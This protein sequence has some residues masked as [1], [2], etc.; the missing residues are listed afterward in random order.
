MKGLHER[1]TRC[2]SP[3]QDDIHEQT[4]GVE[5]ICKAYLQIRDRWRP[6]HA[7]L[8]GV[9]V[10]HEVGRGRSPTS[11]E[12]AL[13]HQCRNRSAKLESKEHYGEGRK[14]VYDGSKHV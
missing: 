12:V 3:T 7:W 14:A 1:L 4:K 6:N 11:L 10:D 9:R 13:F 5:R 8:V 2:C